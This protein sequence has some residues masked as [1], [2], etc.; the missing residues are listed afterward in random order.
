VLCSRT[1]HAAPPGP[2]RPGTNLAAVPPCPTF[3][4]KSWSCTRTTPG[5][6]HASECC[7]HCAIDHHQSSAFG[8]IFARE[9]SD[10]ELLPVSEHPEPEVPYVRLGEHVEEVR[11]IRKVHV[12]VAAPMCEEIVDVVERRH[13][14]DGRI[15]VPARVQRRQV[16]VAFSVD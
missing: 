10:R 16:H 8:F 3:L 9:R 7:G 6:H 1:K 15:D 2:R 13:V 14:R 11:R 12:V 5:S 4:I